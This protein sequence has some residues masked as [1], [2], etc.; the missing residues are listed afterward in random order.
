MTE[1]Q[2]QELLHLHGVLESEE[3]DIGYSVYSYCISCD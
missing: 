2:T 1:F 3:A